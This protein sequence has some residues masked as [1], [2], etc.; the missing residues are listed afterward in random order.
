MRPAATT[1]VEAGLATLA[2]RLRGAAERSEEPAGLVSARQA[3]ERLHDSIAAALGES[4][5][6]F[7]DREDYWRI[8]TLGRAAWLAASRLGAE[9]NRGPAAWADG[10]LQALLDVLRDHGRV[11]SDALRLWLGREAGLDRRFE[12]ARRL[13]AEARQIERRAL[14][15]TLR[16]PE[17]DP[18]VALAYKDQVARAAGAI[19]ACSELARALEL[20]AVKHG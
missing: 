19:R 4:L 8:A 18:S 7:V 15:R 1:D 3:A 11:A 14:A 10:D 5:P 6:V 20:V 13:R 16:D 12:H 9:V 17:A 2:S